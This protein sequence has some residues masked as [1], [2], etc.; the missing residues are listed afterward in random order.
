M[1]IG[2][3]Q[4]VALAQRGFQEN[5]DRIGQTL[6]VEA[7]LAERVQGIILIRLLPDVKRLFANPA[8]ISHVKASS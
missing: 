6:N 1:L 2:D 8:E 4:T 7:Q 3:R 5:T